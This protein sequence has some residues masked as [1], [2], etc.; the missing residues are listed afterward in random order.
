MA[1]RTGT[2]PR[3]LA[4]ALILA[5]TPVVTPVVTP[6]AA[7]VQTKAYD[8]GGVY[9]PAPTAHHLRTQRDRF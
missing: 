2:R 8:N 4:V 5:A 6:A 7:Q 3:L 9:A 1:R